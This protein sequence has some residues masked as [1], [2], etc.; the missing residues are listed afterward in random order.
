[1]K[2]R[3]M[4]LGPLIILVFLG[5]NFYIG[6]NGMGMLSA[7][8]LDVNPY[9]Y[10]MVFIIISF[11]YLLGRIPFLR[12]PIG[13]LLKVIGS[14]YF[15]IL[16]AMFLI[17]PVANIAAWCLGKFE[18]DAQVYIP[19][20]S[21]V[22]LVILLILL[23]RGSWNAWS[24]IVRTYKLNIDKSVGELAG[25][26]IMLASD[27]HLGNI[28]GNRHLAK[29]VNTAERLKPDLILLAGDV[30]DDSIEPFL[31]NQMD[32]RLGQI[33]ARFGV[34]AV[35]GNHE[36]IGGHYEQYIKVMNSMNIKVL[37]DETMLI[38]DLFYVAGR[39][40]KAA[41]S[42]DKAGRI[43][44]TELL[45]GIDKEKPVIMMDHQP[46]EYS[47]AEKAG[48]DLIV[49]GHTHRGQFYPNH[50]FTK[51]LFEL[52]WGYLLKNNMHAIVSSGFGT[53]GPPIRLGSRSEIVEIIINFNAPVHTK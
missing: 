20:I 25:L 29:L 27:L 10:W 11:G 31:R 44:T 26:R 35:L 49:S 14:Y 12:G 7:F 24:P 46:Y 30:L 43:S 4:L 8:S 37:V 40:D 47:V 39:K 34:F 32:K 6:W 9:L 1:M 41:E 17:L 19:I 21:V 13:R 18:F 15:F 51:K 42:M 28:V 5:L 33:Q 48:V 22:V 2:L 23:I 3:Y 53:W 50:L 52:D 38:E 36:Y 16:E 45:A